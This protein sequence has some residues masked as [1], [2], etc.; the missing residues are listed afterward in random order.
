M[1]RTSAIPP[2]QKSA[3]LRCPNIPGGSWREFPTLFRCG[4]WSWAA[5]TGFRIAATKWPRLKRQRKRMGAGDEIQTYFLENRLHRDYGPGAVLVVRALFP[6]AGRSFEHDGSV[7]LG[8]L[9]R[10][11][12]PLRRDAGGRRL[13]H[14]RRGL[15]IQR[16]TPARGCAPRRADRLPWLPAL[17]CGTDV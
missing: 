11:R 8:T 5:F 2:P 15:P 9:D 10:L 7:S 12:L 4:R 6:R 17:Y 16:R 14:G 1:S 3:R 13:L